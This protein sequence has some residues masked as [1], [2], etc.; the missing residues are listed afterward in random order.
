MRGRRN[1]IIGKDRRAFFLKQRNFC[2]FNSKSSLFSF[3]KKIL[4]VLLKEGVKIV[5]GENSK[6]CWTKGCCKGENSVVH[7]G[8]E[9]CEGQKNESTEFILCLYRKSYYSWLAERLK[10][11]NNPQ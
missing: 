2:F 8:F 1:K 3:L 11:N 6:G 10:N 5:K 7:T 4:P 9:S